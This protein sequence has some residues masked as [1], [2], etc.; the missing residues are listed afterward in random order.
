MSDIVRY[1]EYLKF[2]N[3]IKE[4][5]INEILDNL[6]SNLP[7]SI[8]KIEKEN[9]FIVVEDIYYEQDSIRKR[10]I[11]GVNK[12]VSKE[13]REYFKQMGPFSIYVMV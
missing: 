4:N 7:E 1:E 5:K 9:P 3:G 10:F 13:I 6:F 8:K 11:V 12:L 2:K